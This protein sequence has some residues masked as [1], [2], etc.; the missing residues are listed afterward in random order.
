MYSMTILAQS[1][2][3]Q[4][5]E[6]EASPTLLEQFYS[7]H[8]RIYLPVQHGMMIL[9]LIGMVSA[10][11]SLWARWSNFRTKSF[12]PA[13]MAFVFPLLSHTNAVQAYRSGVDTFSSIPVG[14]QFKIA[15]FVYWVA[16][17]IV[18]TIVNLIFTVKYVYRLPEW[19]MGVVCKSG[20]A[21]DSPSVASSALEL[22]TDCDL[23]ESIGDNLINPAVL[24]ANE[25][26]SL[27]RLRRGSADFRTYGPY[28]RT[29]NSM[30]IGFDL[31]RS[32]NELQQERA[33]LLHHIAR[34]LPRG[35]RRT[36]SL[37][38]AALSG[39]NQYGTF[40]DSSMGTSNDPESKTHK[41]TNT[42]QL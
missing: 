39:A 5:Q 15:L 37:P 10:L 35:Q 32:A 19:T 34:K 31:T 38:D 22:L 40:D 42:T 20:V 4:E 8:R 21:N 36:F 6:L 3:R 9:S 12:S 18:G 24:H 26:G 28:M 2:P 14:N 7:I 27:V 13:H 1:F 16:C 33:E 25:I 17:L 30:S 23:H 41:R 29:R 11:Q